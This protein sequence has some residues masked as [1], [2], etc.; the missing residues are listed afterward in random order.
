MVFVLNEPLAS[1]ADVSRHSKALALLS[2][3]VGSACAVLWNGWVPQGVPVPEPV[4]AMGAQ[5][6]QPAKSLQRTQL[7]KARQPLRFWPLDSAE[8]PLQLARNRQPSTAAAAAVMEGVVK[9]FADTRGG[10]KDV[11]RSFER[12]DEDGDGKLNEAEFAK[13]MYWSG[14]NLKGLDKSAIAAMFKDADTDGDSKISIDE[15]LAPAVVAELLCLLPNQPQV[16]AEPYNPRARDLWRK[17]RGTIFSKAWQQAVLSML[18]GVVL[19]VFTRMFQ[20][21]TWAL[22]TLPDPS[23]PF[24]AL[25]LPYASLYQE[26]KLLATFV[27]TFF[28]SQSLDFWRGCYTLAKDIQHRLADMNQ[29]LEEHAARNADG[30]YTAEARSLL[31][32]AARNS[33][34]FYILY[35]AS[36]VDHYKIAS[37]DA[38][39]KQLADAGHCTPEELKRLMQVPQAAR[40]K[41]AAMMLAKQGPKG[42]ASGAL[43]AVEPDGTFMLL[44]HEVSNHL[45][46]TY[47]KIGSKLKAR[48]PMLYVHLVQ[49][50][51]DTLTVLTPFTLY[52]QIGVTSVLLNGLLVTFYQGLLKMCKS[53]LDP[54]GNEKQNNEIMLEVPVFVKDYNAASTRFMEL[55]ESM[56]VKLA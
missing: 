11:T 45:R 21:P 3:T 32:S 31:E 20:K 5:R 42:R 35:W 34:L 44:W 54:Y 12:Y 17:W 37:S 36:M 16:V 27:V 6:V 24:I 48:M 7:A 46:E 41:A 28:V 29:L 25:L 56:P 52:A 10:M 8:R 1:G 49:I 19:T 13:A 23:H 51:V 43:D 30:S 14:A 18:V 40:H 50:L 4:V 22:G 26:Q 53:L 39:L 2:V 33:R 55:G 9:T 15:F 38:G 47:D